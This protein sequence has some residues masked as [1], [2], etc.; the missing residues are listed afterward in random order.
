MK[1][2]TKEFKDIL[3]KVKPGLAQKGIVEQATHFVFTGEDILTYNDE[4]S[5]SHPLETDFECSVPSDILHGVVKDLSG[6]EID[7]S[8]KGNELRIS[9]GKTKA[10]IVASTDQTIMD[11]VDTMGLPEDEKWHP[12]NK[13]FIDGLGLCIFSA[14]KDISFPYMTCISVGGAK[15]VSGDDIRISWYDL[16]H[17]IPDAFL[18]PAAAAVELLKFDI[19]EYALGTS[20]VFF[21]TENDLI[22]CSRIVVDDYPDVE[23]FFDFDGEP[24]I[25]SSD[26]KSCISVVTP[27]A[28]GEFDIDKQIEVAIKDKKIKC[29]SD[30]KSGWAETFIDTKEDVPDL[31]FKVNPFFLSEILDKET[32]LTHAEGKILLE[33]GKLKHLIALNAG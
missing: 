2:R 19:V 20:W 32:K 15:L 8:L 16:E 10:G 5:I 11:M 24:I 3:T 27:M 29:R 9:S 18:L 17:E 28:D 7:L 14:S 1:I 6:K 26:F 31:G 4:I 33:S 12:I 23:A 13:E 30:G 22:F 21:A 25:I